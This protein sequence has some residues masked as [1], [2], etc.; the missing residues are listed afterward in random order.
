MTNVIRLS[1][2]PGRELSEVDALIIDARTSINRLVSLQAQGVN[3]S[4]R[5]VELWQVLNSYQWLVSSLR[6]STLSVFSH[7]DERL[8]D[9]EGL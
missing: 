2:A 1:P 8:A 6:A 7:Q 4:T 5:E 9:K 3:R